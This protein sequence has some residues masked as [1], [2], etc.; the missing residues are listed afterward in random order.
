ML[1]MK[2]HIFWLLGA[3]FLLTACGDDDDYHYP[4]VKLEFVTVESGSDG[5]IQRLIPDEGEALPVSKD[6]TASTIGANTSRRVLSNYEVL[7]EGKG[8]SAEIYSLQAVL[9]L[10]PKPADD[11]IYKDG[12]VHDPVEVVSI[13]LG[14]DYLNMILNLKVNT[15]KGHVF[16][17]VQDAFAD[18]VV[19]MTLYHNANGDGEVYNRRAYISVPLSQ[20]KDEA[21]PANLIKIN[22]D[23][24]TYGKDTPE[25]YSFEYMPSAN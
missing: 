14:K 3:F 20:Y 7:S 24:Y 19:D 13:W 25:R 5:K 17:M 11:P 21:N 12:L 6:R 16:G 10:I 23:Y 18:G 15:G 1:K 9:A 8:M 22:F 2:L 4:S